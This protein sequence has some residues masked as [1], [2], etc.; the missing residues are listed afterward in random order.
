MTGTEKLLLGIHNMLAAGFKV[1]ELAID[2]KE[3]K[4]LSD[5]IVNVSQHYQT[6]ID[7]KLQAWLAL[8]GIVGAIYVPRV[9]ALAQAKKKKDK[10]DIRPR[11]E[12]PTNVMQFDPNQF[13]VGG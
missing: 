8:L 6:V 2:E 12:E 11:G 13:R 3:A 4:M 10:E 9:F 7:P 5:A 1:E